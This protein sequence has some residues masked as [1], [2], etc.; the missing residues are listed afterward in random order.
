MLVLE[1]EPGDLNWSALSGLQLA[2]RE[3]SLASAMAGYLQWLS[4]M[5]EEMRV[6]LSDGVESLRSGSSGQGHRRASTTEA[7]LIIALQNFLIFAH[8]IGAL[9]EESSQEI[10]RRAIEGILAATAAQVP[11]QVDADPVLRFLEMLPAALSS[12]VAHVVTANGGVPEP[13]A[14]WG[15]RRRAHGGSESPGGEWQPQGIKIGWLEGDDLY[16][17]QQAAYRAAQ[18]VIGGAGEVIPVSVRTLARRLNER[19][20]L[21]SIDATGSRL[22]VRRNLEGTRR[23]VLHLASSTVNEQQDFLSADPAGPLR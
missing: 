1:V 7:N 19:G 9:G 14:P 11:H 3:G 20:L 17:D 4:P 2:A 21:R 23:H 16:L 10:E 6:E 12:G 22:T 15:W 5:F 13:A 8:E 18:G